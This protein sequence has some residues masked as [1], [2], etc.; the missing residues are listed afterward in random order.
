MTAITMDKPALRTEADMVRA[1]GSGTYTLSELYELAETAGLAE[2]DGGRDL[3]Q[4][5]QERF[6]RR[7]RNALQ[8]LKRT[9][10]ARQQREVS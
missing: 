4:D 6:K 8:A 7:V 3:V 2:R 10:S 5:G 1:L 9:G